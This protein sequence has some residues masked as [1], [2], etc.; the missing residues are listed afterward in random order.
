MPDILMSNVYL[1]SGIPLLQTYSPWI[2]MS[3]VNVRKSLLEEVSSFTVV[4]PFSRSETSAW[5]PHAFWGAFCAACA[6][7]WSIRESCGRV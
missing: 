6:G 7:S 5:R 1:Y 2:S 3:T 4:T